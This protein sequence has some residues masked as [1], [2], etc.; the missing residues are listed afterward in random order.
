MNRS[1][2][3][4]KPSI[5]RKLACLAAVTIVGLTGIATAWASGTTE[6][7]LIN[8]HGGHILGQQKG[9]ALY[10][11]CT[12]GAKGNVCT[13][14]HSGTNW[15][16]MIA[17]HKPVAG[18]GIKQSKLGTKT[19]GGHKIVT[20]YGQPLYR[21]KGDTKPGQ[22]KGEGKSQGSGGWYVVSKFGQALAPNGY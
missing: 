16:P 10:I 17:Y 15:S 19:I 2:Q 12:F 11:F 1:G 4:F 8:A 22:T 5:S 18:T 21:Y 13:S 9:F 7:K 6:V 3:G 20:Y 14:G